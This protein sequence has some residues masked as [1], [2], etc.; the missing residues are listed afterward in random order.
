MLIILQFNKNQSPDDQLSGDPI[1]V[2]AFQVLGDFAKKTLQAWFLSVNKFYVKFR[3][4]LL[5]MFSNNP[6]E[7]CK[8]TEHSTPKKISPICKGPWRRPLDINISCFW[9]LCVQFMEFLSSHDFHYF[10]TKSLMHSQLFCCSHT[11]FQSR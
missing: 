8:Q 7:V 4:A 2:W 6:F 11:S 10:L 9:N 5:I 3:P 1:K